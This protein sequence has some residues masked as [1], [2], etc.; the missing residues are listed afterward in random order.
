MGVV[1]SKRGFILGRAR[2]RGA[3][4]PPWAVEEN[5][6]TQLCSRCG[7]CIRQCPRNVIRVADGGFPEMDFREAGCD[8]CLACVEACQSSALKRGNLAAFNQTALIGEACLSEKGVVCCSC[9]EVCENRAISFRQ[10]VGGVTRVLM[11]TALCNGCG[12]CISVCPADAISME[13]D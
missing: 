9:G 6:F 8:F 7:E 4:R 1:N 11:D 3:L 2:G 12:E 10:A 5:D 13:K